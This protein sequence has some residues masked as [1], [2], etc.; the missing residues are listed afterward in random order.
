MSQLQ[1]DPRR[2]LLAGLPATEHEVLLAGVS[3]TVLQGGS[4]PPLVLLHGPGGSAVHWMRVLPRLMADHRVIAPDL[5]G[6]GSSQVLDGPLSAEQ[7]LGWLSDLIDATCPA[8][9]ALA[10]N[11]LG[12]AIA[13]RFAAQGPGRLSRLVLVDALGLAPFAPAPEF[14]GALHAFMGEPGPATHEALWRQC[15]LD[16]DSLRTRMGD[17]LW[18]AFEDYNLDRAATQSVQS[19]LGTLMEQFALAPIEPSELDRIASPAALI[20][21]RQDRATPLAVAEATSARHGWPLHVIEDCGDD[22]PLER[23]G[24]FVEAL[25]ATLARSAEA[26]A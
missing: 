17:E 11:A 9:P 5:P 2:R 13:A 4:G 18:Q 10:G 25:A 23:P 15:A 12:G 20:W 26:V 1:P 14:G 6:Q 21:G 22:P 7:V 3:T 19:A 8:P 24:A 16:L